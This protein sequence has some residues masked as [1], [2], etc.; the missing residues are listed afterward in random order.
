MTEIYLKT[1]LP[2]PIETAFDAARNL[3][4]HMDAMKHTAEKMIIGPSHFL[5]ERGDEITWQ[6]RH[7]GIVQQLSVRI[8]AMD[9][10]YA[11]TDEMT[12]GAFK[13]MKHEH[14]FSMDQDRVL[15]E[16]FF[17]YEA[18]YGI[19]GRIFDRLVLKRY[20]TQLLTLRNTTLLQFLSESKIG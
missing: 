19:V 10:P 2:A 13:T 16:D 6:A 20:M 14:R 3:K 5:A 12:K 11:F 1:L 17:S 9:F 15:M 8:T 18:P 7:F 4:L